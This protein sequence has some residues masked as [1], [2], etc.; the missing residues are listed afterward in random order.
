MKKNFALLSALLLTLTS[1]S[2][3]AGKT[4]ETNTTALAE[5]FLYKTGDTG[6]LNNDERLIDLNVTDDY[7]VLTKNK[8]EKTAEITT[9]DLEN[10]QTETLTIPYEKLTGGLSEDY[11]IAADND[12]VYILSAEQN[13]S[14]LYTIDKAQQDVSCT[15]LHAPM[16]MNVCADGNG[17]VYTVYYRYD[18]RM[19][20]V[21]L[22]QYQNGQ[23]TD[24]FELS[25]LL[26]EDGTVEFCDMYADG[27]GNLYVVYTINNTVYTAKINADRSVAA[28]AE[29]S[30]MVGSNNQIVVSGQG[31]LLIVN[32]DDS[33]LCLINKIDPETCETLDFYEE[34]SADDIMNGFGDYDYIVA[35][36]EGFSGVNMEN[37]SRAPL[38]QER[39]FR[40][41]YCAQNGLLT[42]VEI[43]NNY[44]HS[45]VKAEKETNQT[46]SESPLEMEENSFILNAAYQNNKHFYICQ[47]DEKQYLL[48]TDQDGQT[49]S[50]TALDD[51]VQGHAVC[52]CADDANNVYIAST[53]QGEYYY[54]KLDADLHLQGTIQTE[55]IK[56]VRRIVFSGGI[57]YSDS[58][59][60]VLYRLDFEQSKA[61]KTDF[62]CY[63]YDCYLCNGNMMIQDDM[64]VIY[65][66]QDD[67]LTEILNCNELDQI[68]DMGI[69][70][71]YFEGED[72]F[73]IWSEDEQ[74]LYEVNKVNAAD[75]QDATVL[76]IAYDIDSA[77]LKRMLA[78]FSAEHDNIQFKLSDYSTD[79]K[80]EKL[81]MDIAGGNVPDIIISDGRIDLS[82][83]EK[84][85]VLADLTPFF[86]QDSTIS[87]DDYFMNIF[88]AC[89]NTGALNQIVPEFKVLTGFGNASVLGTE[90]GWNYD[91]FLSKIAENPDKEVLFSGLYKSN[92]R[93]VDVLYCNLVNMID[94]AQKKFNTDARYADVLAAL[95]PYMYDTMDESLSYSKDEA[96][97]EYD[98]RFRKNKVLFDVMDISSVNDIM[99]LKDAVVGDEIVFKGLPS[100]N[101]KGSYIHP[102]TKIA[103]LTSCKEQDLAW[104]FMKQYL[105]DAYQQN[106]SVNY[107]PVK[108]SAFAANFDACEERKIP[109]G[110]EFADVHVPTEQ[111]RAMITDWI[112]S[113]DC[114]VC[115]E[116]RLGNII[117]NELALYLND[118]QNED[119]TLKEI[120]RKIELYLSEV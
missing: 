32:R 55:G 72:Q 69:S 24:A 92:V 60:G 29:V 22:E 73:Y 12:H 2:G 115:T 35:D 33:N 117:Y 107:F 90:Q 30:G 38:Q 106:V 86:D 105:D 93:Y 98:L 108:K 44:N 5:S 3:C 118:E 48:I 77:A 97:E 66:V 71:I 120:K 65:A 16:A 25:E 19:Q 39:Q 82:V 87:T 67:S 26:A 49:E 43:K 62:G 40:S 112:S 74:T 37:D 61:E 80:V 78:D 102:I 50:K 34:D 70:D 79:E 27:S 59:D 1:A 101:G 41:V 8:S 46:V 83:Y 17:S 81:N 10:D 91:E 21:M 99:T 96:T 114:A 64:G 54:Q 45:L 20:Y 56:G 15:D 52:V 23:K 36:S 58:N 53:L 14:V 6:L 4:Q 88:R 111:D 57:A 113:I 75:M 51:L 28:K 103:M 116:N 85:G 68:N 7:L 84:M 18:T 109:V 42:D 63:A 110:S 95:K 9:A 104:E 100:G 47:E 13:N 89:S 76:N 11:Q 31:A 94:F 119:Q